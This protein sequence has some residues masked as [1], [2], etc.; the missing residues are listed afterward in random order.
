MNCEPV[1][2]K[3]VQTIA[4]AFSGVKSLTNGLLKHAHFGP[5]RSEKYTQP[6]NYLVLSTSFCT[7]EQ[8]KVYKN[9]DAYKYFL[10][11]FVS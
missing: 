8:F 1:V 9:M 2:A 10:S 11:G 6:F 4:A 5:V 7:S 3:V